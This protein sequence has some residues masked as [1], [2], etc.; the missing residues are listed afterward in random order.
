MRTFKIILFLAGI[1]FLTSVSYRLIYPEWIAFAHAEKLYKKKK[2]DEAIY[3]YIYAIDL[4]IKS[5]A[6]VNHLNDSLNRSEDPKKIADMLDFFMSKASGNNKA[7][8]T[9]AD[10]FVRIEEY[11][12]AKRIYKHI[13]YLFPEHIIDRLKLAKIL[14]RIGQYDE[15]IEEYK[16]ALGEK[17]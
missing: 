7:M 14:N 2:Y 16:L 3:S 11:N 6:I 9:L 17:I 5:T 15:A 1:A 4:G 12:K 10:F 8:E 13:L